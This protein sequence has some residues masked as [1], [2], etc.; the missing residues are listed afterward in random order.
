MRTE[1]EIQDAIDEI[2]SKLRAFDIEDADARRAAAAKGIALMWV[3]KQTSK[4]N[5]PG[6][7]I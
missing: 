5:I 2:R 1:E 4:L 7:D 6:S 3:L